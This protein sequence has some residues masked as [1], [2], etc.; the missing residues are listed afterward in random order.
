VTA[1][2]GEAGARGG[3]RG[4]WTWAVGA[5]FLVLIA[6]AGVNALRTEG[7]GSRGAAAGT[8]LPPF[9][10][11][12][13]G[14]TVRGDANVAVTASDRVRRAACDVRGAGIF[15]SCDAVAARPL[16]LTFLADPVAACRR[17]VD[18]LD[19]FGRRHPELAVTAV[20]LRGRRDALRRLARARGWRLPVVHDADGAVWNAYAVSV[21]PM[22]TFAHRGGRVLV[23]AVEQLGERAIAERAR[24]LRR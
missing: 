9:A 19:S 5:V 23:T 4:N 16:I 24:R 14:G 7:P 20:A 15:N 3:G 22:T 18:A 17:Q 10:A 11:P 12:L 13:V 21:C 8:R 2:R 1:G 6:V